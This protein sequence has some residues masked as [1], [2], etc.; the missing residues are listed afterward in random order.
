MGTLT[1]HGVKGMK[2]GVINELRKQNENRL[3]LKK[4]DLVSHVTKDKALN[5][6]PGGLYV[7]FTEKDIQT[8][9]TEYKEFIEGTR[10]AS[11][12]YSYK[13]KA[14]EDIVTPDLKTKVD[15]FVDI[16]KKD[17]TG[18]LFNE[19]GKNKVNSNLFLALGRYYGHDTKD[20]QAAKYRAMVNSDDPKVQEKAFK[21]FV[22]YLVFT[23][24][25]RQ[26]YFNK[27]SK[28][29]FNAM[30]DDFD[31]NGGYSE[32]PLIVFN[33]KKTVKIVSKEII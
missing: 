19:M 32:A 30:F 21:A 27:L 13:M 9:R 2:W 12:V 1:H 26:Q 3:V 17:T 14:L 20:K 7:S 16:Y 4:G 25:T 11:K 10:N 8:Y 6:R 22:Q 29:G 33:P 28:K 23:P 24:K 15:T 18:K 5:P 31:M